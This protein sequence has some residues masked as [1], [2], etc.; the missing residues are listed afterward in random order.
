[1]VNQRDDNQFLWFGLSISIHLLILAC[2]FVS[3]MNKPSLV[4]QPK[5]KL[6]AFK[7]PAPVV[8]YGQQMA[9][10]KR[11][12]SMNTAQS[13]TSQPKPQVLKKPA[14]EQK[15]TKQE[16]KEKP[17][18]VA[19]Q[20]KQPTLADIFNHARQ[21][22]ASSSRLTDLQAHGDGAG[23]PVVIR[24]GD[25]KYYSLWSTFLNHLNNAA[26]FNRVQNP[27]PVEEW[28]RSKKITQNMQCA[29]TI[30][31]KGEVQDIDIVA[32]SG[33]KAFDAVCVED[34]WSASPFP[35]LPDQ[36]GKTVARFEVRSYI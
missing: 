8:F 1:V 3:L 6:F 4:H 29:I 17:L 15:I 23:Q 35:P 7:V 5:K 25:M 22:F 2:L 10:N 20:K 13:Q 18:K 30:N 12:G 19:P 31:K 16:I 24:E 34:I 28:L 14:Q 27:V 32:S 9:P 36:L 33:L 26:R 11:P 21:T